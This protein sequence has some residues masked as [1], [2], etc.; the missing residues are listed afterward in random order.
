MITTCA[1][2]IPPPNVNP[3]TSLVSFQIPLLDVSKSGQN[4]IRPEY[5]VEDVAAWMI[6]ALKK[7]NVRVEEKAGRSESA[8]CFDFMVARDWR[9][10]EIAYHPGTEHEFGSWLGRISRPPGVLRL[11]F[12]RRT[13]ESDSSGVQLIDSIL[14]S[15]RGVIN[16]RWLD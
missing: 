9:R 12:G 13:P 5:F 10:F 16:V 14:T 3:R 11:W 7:H 15:S 1:R 8:H 2:E 6:A 4:A